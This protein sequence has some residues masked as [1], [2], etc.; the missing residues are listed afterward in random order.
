MVELTFF[1]RHGEPL[2]GVTRARNFQGPTPNCYAEIDG[3]SGRSR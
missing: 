3:A 2:A 1:G